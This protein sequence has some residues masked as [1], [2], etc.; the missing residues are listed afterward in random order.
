ERIAM[1]RA[2]M[3]AL[4]APEPAANGELDPRTAPQRRA[5]AMVLIFEKLLRHGDLPSSRGRAPQVVVTVDLAT[6]KGQPDATLAQLATGSALTPE[7]VRLLMCDAEITPIVLDPH[8]VPLS[9]G[10]THRTVTPGIWTALVARDTGCV[11]PGCTQPAWMSIAHHVEHWEHGGET[12]LENSALLC[13]KHHVTVH[14]RGWD[15]R[16]GEDGLPELIPPTWLDSTQTPRR[17]D[18]WRLQKD[19]LDPPDPLE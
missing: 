7:A 1:A 10:R 9:V 18:Y 17:N 8:G 14:H 4:D 15:C 12:S 2:A 19:L 5:D 13:G 3:A 16:I 6:L 11:F